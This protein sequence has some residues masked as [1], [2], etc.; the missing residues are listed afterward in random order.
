M[1][2]IDLQAILTSIQEMLGEK[3]NLLFVG[4]HARFPS[5]PI[6]LPLCLRILLR[7][8]NLFHLFQE[9]GQDDSN[10]ISSSSR[11]GDKLSVWRRS[12]AASPRLGQ[13][14]A[15]FFRFYTCWSSGSKV[16]SYNCRHGMQIMKNKYETP[17]RR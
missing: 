15:A 4:I 3:E 1:T 10:P 2:L 17:S 16:D 14:E 11:R 8:E 7:Q 6:H 5:P 12:G 13:Y 9:R